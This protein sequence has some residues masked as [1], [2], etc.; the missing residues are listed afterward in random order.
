MK[1]LKLEEKRFIES[2]I[3]SNTASLI[4]RNNFS[5]SKDYVDLVKISIE[6]AQEQLKQRNELFGYNKIKKEKDLSPIFKSFSHL[7]I[8]E[9][10]Y[11]LLLTEYSELDVLDCFEKIQNYKE[12]KKYKSLFLTSKQWLKKSKKENHNNTSNSLIPIND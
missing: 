2:A 1:G 5:D 4:L 3:L 7:S 11:N 12:N 6:I 10:E 8:T 9:N